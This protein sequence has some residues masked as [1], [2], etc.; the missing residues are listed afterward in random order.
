LY[1]FSK[2]N[3][4][5][6][7]LRT[8][9]FDNLK[10]QQ[11]DFQ[12]L[13]DGSVFSFINPLLLKKLAYYQFM[14]F[15]QPY[16]RL[17]LR[18]LAA[19]LCVINRIITSFGSSAY[20]VNEIAKKIHDEGFT[21]EGMMNEYTIH[22][23]IVSAF[24]L[25]L[26]EFGFLKADGVF[27]SLSE[28][29]NRKKEC[30]KAIQVLIDNSYIRQKEELNQIINMLGESF[31][32]HDFSLAFLMKQ[33]DPS[34]QEE[35]KGI[36]GRIDFEK[37]PLVALIRRRATDAIGK[38]DWLASAAC[39]QL[40]ATLHRE[41]G[42][43]EWFDYCQSR[44][45]V[46][47]AIFCKNNKTLKDA[48]Q[49]YEKAAE[50][51]SKY[52]RHKKN[53]ILQS[54]NALGCKARYTADEHNYVEASNYY[55]Q[56]SQSFKELGMDK[57]SAFCK[58]HALQSQA[59]NQAAA[60]EFVAASELAKQAASVIEPFDK[61][62]YFDC[63]AES[64]LYIREL[65]RKNDD[66]EGWTKSCRLA[67]DNFMKAGN[68]RAYYR[69]LAASIQSE[70][71]SLVTSRTPYSDIAQKYKLA[72]DTYTE[73]LDLEASMV[74]QADSCKY[75]GLDAKGQGNL[76]EA[77][78]CFNEARLIYQELAYSS[79]DPIAVKTYK[80]GELWHEAMLVETTAQQQ[81]L[82]AIPK[83]EELGDV[84]KML[85]H[86]SDLFSKV[87]DVK[88]A[89]IDS[90]F[91]MVT[92]AIDAF[93]KGDQTNAAALLQEAKLRLPPDF[94]YSVFE[95]EV[96]LGWQPL[97]YTLAMMANFNKYARKIETEKGF[98]F[99]SRVRELLRKLFPDCHNIEPKIFN[100]TDDEVGI[101]FKDKTPIEID[102]FGMRTRDNRYHILVAEIKNTTKEVGKDE[103]VK[104]LKKINFV[105]KRYSQIAGLES[106]DKPIIE[107][108][109]F[110]SSSGFD[111]NARSIAEKN[112]IKILQK[113]EIAAL[114]RDNGINPVP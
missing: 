61:K 58:L 63:I 92:M 32:L 26:K 113:D 49:N 64:C 94:V 69:Y 24:I 62:H 13:K 48:A 60:G 110:L 107:H 41:K 73:S 6:D 22:E 17:T 68:V 28:E 7:I 91:V 59:K 19:I 75:S 114:M 67:A 109:L 88:H 25:G 21:L 108:K 78:T 103:M 4:E 36:L 40:E 12:R 29:E 96:K 34:L 82:G 44:G 10:N 102:G 56:A 71:K 111:P 3:V 52:P 8:V 53:A 93:H 97:R 16:Y 106:M 45:Y 80:N 77:I 76:Q 33:T 99:E 57:E 89:E 83:Q 30:I 81:L 50:I 74:C 47:L 2:N 85:T 86:A 87:G 1:Y 90:T 66:F 72:S 39:W 95:D 46:S 18:G 9:F 105:E 14:F 15:Q 31:L 38:K 65:A 51:M 104:F 100:P 84:A 27:S 112:N 11:V 35:L 37:Q 101:V 5:L 42:E 79:Q 54:A 20:K 43:N 98:S 23:K 55:L 70:A